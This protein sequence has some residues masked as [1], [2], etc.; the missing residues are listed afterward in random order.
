MCR[1]SDPK[2]K[3]Q[4]EDISTSK[5]LPAPVLAPGSARKPKPHIIR[6]LHYARPLKPPLGAL[7]Q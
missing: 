2:E 6:R 5:L 7:C 3:R 4:V 1:Y